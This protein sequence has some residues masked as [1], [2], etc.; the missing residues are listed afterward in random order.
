MLRASLVVIAR[1]SSIIE[2]FGIFWI[3]LNWKINRFSG[4]FQ[5]GKLSKFQ[6]LV[7]FGI[8]RPFD[9]S[10]HS[11]FRRLLA[12]PSGI[13]IK[14]TFFSILLS[15]RHGRLSTRYTASE[16][17]RGPE[18]TDW[19]TQKIDYNIYP[20]DF[21]CCRIFYEIFCCALYIC[22]GRGQNLERPIFW[23]SK[24]VN[25]EITK[26]ELFDI[27]IFEFD[28]LFFLK[29]FEL[30]KYLIIFEIAKF[31]KLMIFPNWKILK[32]QNFQN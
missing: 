16:Y 26:H 8:V 18:R 10:H 13:I 17:L 14:Y 3:S 11:Q 19:R 12:I 27:F 5:I 31:S 28:L 6:I 1:S 25:I 24:I 32:L 15:A 23:N 7:N 30:P 9:I 21:F 2:I 29:L 4:L 20:R 22:K